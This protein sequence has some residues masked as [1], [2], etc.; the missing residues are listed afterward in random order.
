[1]LPALAAPDADS[2]APMRG[3]LSTLSEPQA[4]TACLPLIEPPVPG[5]PGVSILPGLKK[6][7]RQSF[8]EPGNVNVNPPLEIFK[9]T[10]LPDLKENGELFLCWSL[11]HVCIFSD[12]IGRLDASCG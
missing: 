4:A 3:F 11:M 6:R 8:C 7:I 2:T 9:L 10:V 12:Q 1:M 5:V